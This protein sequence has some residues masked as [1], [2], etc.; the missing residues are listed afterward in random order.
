MSRSI[1][2]SSL[3]TFSSIEILPEVMLSS[4]ADHAQGRRLAA[5]RWPDQNHEFLVVDFEV[6]VL[7]RVNLVI[8]LVQ[9]AHHDTGHVLSLD[10]SGD[11]GHV[12]FD[13]ERIDEGDGID[14]S[15]APAISSPQK[16]TSP[17]TSSEVT[18]TGTVFCSGEDR[19]T[20]A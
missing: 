14:P 16:N 20:S 2:G 15:S 10:R 19:N 17:R 9:A 1:G 5:A 12:V 6:H 7:D 11:A 3:T 18:P 13:E 8:F 4:P